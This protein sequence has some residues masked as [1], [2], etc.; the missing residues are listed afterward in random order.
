M[1]GV[2]GADLRAVA[3]AREFCSRRPSEF[4][5]IVARR[6]LIPRD[7]RRP[8]SPPTSGPTGRAGRTRGALPARGGEWLNFV[9]LLSE[10]TGGSNPDRRGTRDEFAN[11]FRA[12]HP[13]TP[14]SAVD[15]YKW[16]VR[17]AADAGLTQGRVTPFG[18][19]CHAML[20]MLAQGA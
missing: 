17:A 6:G 15:A 20:P 14:A 11:D 3:R 5:G 8:V 16:A 18:D 10:T 7:R 1:V 19:A 9:G 13:S 2:I 12:W 4:T